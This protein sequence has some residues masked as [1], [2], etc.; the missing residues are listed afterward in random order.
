MV[1]LGNKHSSTGGRKD[2]MFCQINESS[3]T[4]E[5]IIKPGW[6]Q[7]SAENLKLISEILVWTKIKPNLENLTVVEEWLTRDLL[8]EVELKIK[9]RQTDI[10]YAAADEDITPEEVSKAAMSYLRQKNDPECD[11][12]SHGYLT[13]IRLKMLNRRM[14]Q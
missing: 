9:G 5:C 4:R 1:A 8:V 12:I 11:Q 2:D 6:V 10:I 7:M 3:R 13:V 14:N